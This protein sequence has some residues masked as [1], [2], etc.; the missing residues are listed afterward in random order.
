MVA[1]SLAIPPPDYLSSAVSL[2]LGEEGRPSLYLDAN[3]K[4]TV[5]SP[6]VADLNVIVRP[7]IM[8]RILDGSPANRLK[9]GGG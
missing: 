5:E 2:R 8:I 1:L 6:L 7:Q 3:K 4:A 9:G